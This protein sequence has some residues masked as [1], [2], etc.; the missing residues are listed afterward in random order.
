VYEQLG[1]YLV[2]IVIRSQISK[3]DTDAEKKDI[4][5][6]KITVQLAPN[7]NF[8]NNSM[9]RDSVHREILGD[10]R[11]LCII[12]LNFI[13]VYKGIKKDALM[14]F[15]GLLKKSFSF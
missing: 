6:T 15:V 14:D 13:M 11:D 10:F 7:K 8:Y 9:L 12:I 1:L 5:E 2:E 3:D 4:K